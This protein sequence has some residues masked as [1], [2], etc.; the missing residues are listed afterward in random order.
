METKFLTIS[1]NETLK[2]IYNIFA[3]EKYNEILVLDENNKLYGIITLHVLKTI[4]NESLLNNFLL[5]A[6]IANTDLIVVLPQESLYA[7]LNKIGFRKINT[8][9]VVKS[10]ET[11]E[12]IGIIRRKSVLRR[13]SQGSTNV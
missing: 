5:A 6:D 3:N 2:E 4:L 13:I 7:L 1:K 9:P 11:M 8:V 12:V 10:L